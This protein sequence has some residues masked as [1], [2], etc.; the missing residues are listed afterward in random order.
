M[1]FKSKYSMQIQLEYF[2]CYLICFCGTLNAV[3]T[4]FHNFKWK[5]DCKNFKITSILVGNQD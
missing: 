2:N 5:I 3:I 1:H 4:L